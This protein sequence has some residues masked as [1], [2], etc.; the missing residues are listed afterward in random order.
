[1]LASLT[2]LSICKDINL[3]KFKAENNIGA[4]GAQAIALALRSHK[5]LS[6]LSISI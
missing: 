3:I 6:K 2:K 1:M 4:E 5:L